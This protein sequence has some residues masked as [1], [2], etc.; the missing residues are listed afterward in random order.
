MSVENFN[1]EK[2]NSVI[3]EMYAI[4]NNIHLLFKTYNSIYQPIFDLLDKIIDDLK[5][6]KININY[7]FDDLL[8]KLSS[9]TENSE[10]NIK[11]IIDEINLCKTHKKDINFY[12]ERLLHIFKLCQ[13][14]LKEIS[15]NVSDYLNS[16]NQLISKLS[17]KE[18]SDIKVSI[19]KQIT[20]Y[21]I[22]EVFDKLIFNNLKDCEFTSDGFT[23]YT[24]MQEDSYEYNQ[25][26]YP[27]I[28]KD[29]HIKY[30]K[31]ILQIIECLKQFKKYY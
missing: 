2:V 15:V 4:F 17:L 3:K 26:F 16:I 14:D 24:I 27:G 25:I 20:F 11:I 10:F 12:K 6:N 29:G 18:Y 8:N 1:F 22:C 13:I 9:I 31:N 19:P 21:N 7:D 30:Y 23:G 28:T 5:N